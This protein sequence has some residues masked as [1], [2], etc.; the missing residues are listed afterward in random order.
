MNVNST[1]DSYFLS[2]MQQGMLFHSLHAPQS[3]VD[4][5]QLI[6]A[7]HENLSVSAF[8]RSWQRVIERHPVLRTSFSW[9]GVNEPLQKVHRQVTLPWVERDWRDVSTKQQELRLEAYLQ[10]DRQRGFEITEAPLMRLALFRLAEAEY[11]FIWTFHHS[12]LD[13]R[14]LPLV[15]KELFAFYEAFCRDRE[16]QLEQSRPYR[17]YIDWLGLQD[18][19]RAESFWRQTLGNFT[20]PTPLVVDRNPIGSE[21]EGYGK[22]GIRLFETLTSALQS[23]AQQHELTLNTLVQGAWALLLSRYSGE[24]DVVFGATRACRRSVKGSESMVGLFINTLP[25]RSRTSPEKLLLPWLKELR[26]QWVAMRDYEHTPLVKVQGWSDIPPGKPL[27]ESILVFENYLLN[28][29]LRSLGGSANR[30]FR[31]LEQTN[32][33]LTAIAN[34]EAEL[35]LQI[36]YSRRRFDDQTITRMLGHVRTLLESMVANPEQRLSDLSLLTTAERQMLVDW[37]HTQ[38]DSLK[39]AC[40]HQLFEAQVERTPKAVAVVFEDQQ[41]TYRELNRRA[42]CLAHYLQKLGVGPEVLVGI[43]VERSLEMVVGLLGILKAGGAFVPLDPEYPKS[44]LAFMLRDT[45]APILLTQQRLIAR[46]PESVAEVVCLDG[47]NIR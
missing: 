42:N 3:G 29:T 44:R 45:Q 38:V 2:A 10:D 39:Q 47:A 30:E 7:L 26:A 40:I 22:Q 16:L 8:R 4:I 33:P 41:L 28:S 43:C 23:L 21:E 20:A 18:F 25:V 36:A 27:F 17:D 6:C 5:E 32:Y 13:G 1:E 15:L 11:Q 24:E 31:L 19:T 46:L 12:L 35:S 34:V 37:N 14:S 9:Q